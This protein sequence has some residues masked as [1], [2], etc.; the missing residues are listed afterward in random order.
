MRQENSGKKLPLGRPDGIIL[1]WT[2]G[3][4]DTTYDHYHFCV[5][6]NGEVVQTLSLLYRG[7][8]TWKR[9]TGKIGISMCCMF[10]NKYP[11]TKKQIEATAK[12]VADLVGIFGLDWDQVKDHAYYAKIDGY[13]NLRWDVGPYLDTIIQKAKWYRARVLNGIDENKY[14]GKVK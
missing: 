10:S 13:S 4:Y 8:H 12:L 7:S 11:P 14:V 6:G 1:H 2:A 9:N 5:K 3:N